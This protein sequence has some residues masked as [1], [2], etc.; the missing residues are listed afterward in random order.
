M[1]NITNSLV[2]N[3]QKPKF[4]VAIQSDGYKNLIN[5]TLRDPKRA[6]RFVANIM[7]AVATNPMLSDCDAGTI[8][9]AGLLGETLNLSPSAQLGQFYLV[10]FN[11]KQRGKVATFQLGWHGYVQLAIRSGYYKKLNVLPIKK[12]ELIRF[13]PLEEEIEIK[14]IEDDTIREA[15]ET[16]GYYAFFEY[17]NGFKKAMYWSR[18][19]MEQHA[20]KY[21]QGYRADKSKGTEYTFWSKDFD[22][23]AMKTMLRQLISKW[24]IMSTE[25][26]EAFIKDQAVINEKGEVDYVDNINSDLLDSPTQEIIQEETKV[27]EEPTLTRQ[28]SLVF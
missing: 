1:A 16:T 23:M 26:Q 27:E 12:G 11:D 9:S 6:N 10:P 7:S 5:N 2:K 22:G 25:M 21:S 14:L 20:L 13:N 18:E 19:K 4:S 24:G 28:Q 15:T 3:N 8:L 17:T